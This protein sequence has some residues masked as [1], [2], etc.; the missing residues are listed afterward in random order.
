MKFVKCTLKQCFDT[1]KGIHLA[2]LQIHSAPIGVDL[3]YPAT[4]LFNR[5]VR[6]LLPQRISDPFNI[7]NDDMHYEAIA[8]C[9]RKYDKDKDT[10]KD[11]FVF[12]AGATVAVQ[13]EN[14]GLWAHGVR[15]N[16]KDINQRGCF[17]TI[18]HRNQPSCPKPWSIGTTTE[19]SVSQ[20]WSSQ[21]R[22]GKVRET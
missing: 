9:Q 2:L 13:W 1:N 11:N 3:Q 22:E 4:M 12:I 20:S 5:L 6:S 8:A 15:V 17:C 19:A 18:H 7:K 14:G 21:S 10:Q 16:P